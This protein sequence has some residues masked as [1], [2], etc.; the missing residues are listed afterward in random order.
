M[1]GNLIPWKRKNEGNVKVWKEEQ[2][3]PIAQLRR[4][5]DD[6][7]DRFWS[8]WSTGGL[9]SRN[10]SGWFGPRV[11]WDDNEK[12][13]VLRADLPGFEPE[14]FEVEVTG[15]V[16]TLRAEHKEK[17]KMKNGSYRRYGNFSETFTL[18]GGV[19]P[20][21]IDASYHSGVLELHLPKS[22]ESQAKRIPVTAA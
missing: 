18:P 12:E 22:E 1:F 15:N 3:H 21:K 7:W 17:G 4:E 5:F 20:D 11:D 9:S 2:D 8:G 14:D 10:D 19:L 6:M 13:Y 16:L